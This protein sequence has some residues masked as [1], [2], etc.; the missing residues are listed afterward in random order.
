MA[1]RGQRDRVEQQPEL[2]E[3]RDWSWVGEVSGDRLK[4]YKNYF[5]EMIAYLL[6]DN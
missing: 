5:N 2:Y 1:K 4:G 3:Q 6:D